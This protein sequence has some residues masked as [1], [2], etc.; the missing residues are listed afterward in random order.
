M[1]SFYI[2]PPRKTQFG[3][4]GISISGILG[5]KTNL[6]NN[7][8]I[9]EVG[10]LQLDTNF[11]PVW[12]AE[13]IFND[14]IYFNDLVY[15]SPEQRFNIIQLTIENQTQGDLIS[16]QG[17]SWTRWPLGQNNQ[18][19]TTYNNNLLWTNQ[20]TLSTTIIGNLITDSL[21]I[22][23]LNGV[24][25]A[26]SGIVSGLAIIND[27]ND[28]NINT[29][30]LQ[31]Y[32]KYDGDNWVNANIPLPDRSLVIRFFNGYT[33]RDPD[34]LGANNAE[35]AIVPYEPSTG[36]DVLVFDVSRIVLQIQTIASSGTSSVRIQRLSSNLNSWPDP[37]SP[38]A[39][40]IVNL[41]MDLGNAEVFKNKISSP[42]LNIQI[43]SGQKLRA[44]VD[45]IGVNANYW[46]L[47]LEASAGSLYTIDEGV[48][49]ISRGG[50]G[51]STAGTPN[52]LLTVSGSGEKLVYKSLVAGTNVSITH[53]PITIDGE[54]VGGEIVIDSTGGGGGNGNIGAGSAGQFTYYPSNGDTLGPVSSLFWN[55]STKGINLSSVPV[56]YSTTTVSLLVGGTLF[57][58]GSPNGTILGFN[59]P[60]NP[61]FTG[62]FAD[63]QINNISKFSIAYDGSVNIFSTLASNNISSGALVV[64]GGVGI[65]G[66]LNLGNPLASN[67]GG[68]GYASFSDN[69]ILIG[70]TATGTL[71]KKTLLQG[72]RLS[73]V[74][75]PTTLTF[76][77]VGSGVTVDV[78][79]PNNPIEGD[80]WWKSD[81]G[82]LK[83]SYKDENDDQYWVDAFSPG[84]I[85]ALNLQSANI[86][87]RLGFAP[88][89]PGADVAEIIVP[90]SSLD[91]I[92][93]VEFKIRRIYARVSVS[94]GEPA[95]RFEKSSTSGAFSATEIGTL[96][97][98]LDAY[99]SIKINN[100][101]SQTVTSGDKIRINFL[102]LGTANYFT[103]GIEISE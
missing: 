84:N 33:P 65:S 8:P 31:Q 60:T 57:N 55:D 50:T 44:V 7:A 47:Q 62:N 70:D 1:P 24:L 75:T 45:S 96:N 27:L 34:D 101:N 11:A 93:P 83:I 3:E 59:L 91:G 39:D 95:I 5:V 42:P 98:S 79:P 67:S 13:H 68:T 10:A 38:S 78:S 64:S 19:L 18:I 25:K 48:L 86:I 82:S 81:T 61:S 2:I 71:K 15:F 85:A 97:F 76:N 37:D 22:D 87:I 100:F 58:N 43:S 9:T 66:N 4:F 14:K 26:N 51:R 94:G 56:T 28:V 21:Q 17:T 16:Y 29:P 12:T 102:S 54:E 72:N 49:P 99:E 46:I 35:I 92:T 53:V 40:I 89:A 52:T 80:L 90:F 20:L 73:I 6:P 74:S 63:F 32:L 36:S 77:A 41:T 30:S 88:A 69:Q 23:S 103:C